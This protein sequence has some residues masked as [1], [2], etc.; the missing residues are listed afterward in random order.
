VTRQYGS[1]G[2][3][4]EIAPGLFRAQPS[5]GGRRYSVSANTKAGVIKAIRK[6]HADVE[7]RGAVAGSAMTLEAYLAVW[8]RDTA[9]PSVRHTTYGIYERVV[10]LHV[11]PR[12][13]R[14]RLSDLKPEHVDALLAALGRETT[15]SPRGR[16]MVRDV[17][18]G[19]LQRAVRRGQLTRNAASYSTPI[20]VPT[21]NVVPWT[22]KEA[23]AILAAAAGDRLEALYILALTLG[24]REGELFGLRW[25]DVDFDAGTVTVANNAALVEDA[26]G[27]TA[28]A[29]TTT[30]TEGSRRTLHAP[31]MAMEA[32][33]R[34]EAIGA[35]EEQLAGGKYRADDL[36]F[37][38]TLGTVMSATNFIKRDWHGLLAMAGVPYRRFHTC[39]HSAATFLLALGYDLFMVSKTLGHSQITLTANLYGHLTPKIQA[40]AAN[41]IGDLLA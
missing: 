8:L 19:A 17:L 3:I 14:L 9:K 16:Q 40:E 33:R 28:A 7:A 27:R 31:D 24:L 22:P 26:R 34:R 1:G 35:D 29:L 30:K 20:K 10:R 21:A 23:R 15:L 2:A 18:R 38:S 12:L 41:R 4:K 32:L 6:L 25:Q 11:V 36:V 37:P 13:G 39:R 5:I